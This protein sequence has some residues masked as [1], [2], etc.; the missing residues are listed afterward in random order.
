MY[1]LG[2]GAGTGRAADSQ[3][4]AHGREGCSFTY[5][6]S[7]ANSQ[8]PDVLGGGLPPA[9][10]ALGRTINCVSWSGPNLHS[11]AM[12]GRSQRFF[13]AAENDSYFV[14]AAEEENA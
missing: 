9:A 11:G 12:R 2:G 4:D 1:A 14:F 10:R 13:P 6:T 5:Q 7:M 3:P 8:R